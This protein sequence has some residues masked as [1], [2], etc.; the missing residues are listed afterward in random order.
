MQHQDAAPDPDAMFDIH[1]LRVPEVLRDHAAR[2]R[3]PVRWVVVLGADILLL[4][5][6]GEVVDIC[7][8]D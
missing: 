8:L 7:A 1:D 3:T 5:A 4:A 6:D 2:F